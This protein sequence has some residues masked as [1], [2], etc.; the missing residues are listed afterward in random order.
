M[1]ANVERTLEVAVHP[2]TSLPDHLP[3]LLW[4]LF[5]MEDTS[6]TVLEDVRIRRSEVQGVMVYRP[7]SGTNARRQ[8]H[9]VLARRVLID[10]CIRVLVNASLSVR[11]VGLNARTD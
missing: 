4:Q 11:S 3:E 10:G 7:L 6:V 1:S 5:Q 2:H 8:G 9:S